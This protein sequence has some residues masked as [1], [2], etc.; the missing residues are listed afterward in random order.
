MAS[1][2]LITGVQL[3]MLVGLEDIGK[4]QEIA[5]E[6]EEDQYIGYSKKSVEVDVRNLRQLHKEV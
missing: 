4:R 5:E 1:R 2:Y 3:G 6:I